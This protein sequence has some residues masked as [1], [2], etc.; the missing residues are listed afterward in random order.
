MRTADNRVGTI[1]RMYEHDLAARYDAGERRAI[2]RT[3]FHEQ[4]GWDAARLEMH[5][6]GTLSESELLKV[7]DPLKRLIAGEPLQYVLGGTWFHGMRLRV[8]PGVLIPRPETE[9]MVAMILERTRPPRQFVDVGTGSGCIA[10]ALRKAWPASRAIGVDASGE[11]LRI[12]AANGREQGLEVEWLQADVL[13]PGFRLPEG[14]ELVVSNPPY[15]PR[16]E[17]RSLAEHVRAH[18]PAAALF[19]D[20]DDPLCFFRRIATLAWEGMAPC[21]SLWFEGHHLHSGTVGELLA[22][23]GFRDVEVIKDLSGTPRFI[24]ATR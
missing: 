24:H 19:V 10:L 23:M 16:A 8:G 7:Y 4:L 22:A 14:T 15:V 18:E 17:A 3:V 1:L 9:E 20:D 6:D 11:A 5:R 13:A 2:V 21:G 12:A